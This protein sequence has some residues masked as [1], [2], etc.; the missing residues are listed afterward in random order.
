[1]SNILFA[2]TDTHGFFTTGVYER[3]KNYQVSSLLRLKPDQFGLQAWGHYK[4]KV[5]FDK[6]NLIWLHLNPRV[7]APPWFLFPALIKRKAPDTTLIISH[8]FFEK[9]YYKPIPYILKKYFRRADYIHVNTVVAKEIIE[10]SDMD[11]PVLYVH[12]GQPRV[13]E[14]PWPRPLP[15]SEREGIFTIKHSN[16]E[17]TMIRKFEIG[18][19]A[20]LPMTVINSEPHTD[21]SRLQALADAIGVDAKCYGRLDW[22]EYI[23]KLR[24][25]RVAIDLGYVGISRISYEAAKVRVPVVGSWL[26]EFRNNLYPKLGYEPDDVEGM[27][28]RVREIHDQSTA[29]SLNRTSCKMIREYWSQEVCRNRLLE[30]FEE[31]GYEPELS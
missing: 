24:R 27:A 30:L 23:D 19:M 11:V 15:W 13:D 18:K 29:Q 9:Y 8:E 5:D 14:T 25:C 2:D 7:M 22:T 21:G 1:M 12:I 6:Y 16:P 4:D 17:S 26:L 20:G 31:I 10:D 3:S 28:G